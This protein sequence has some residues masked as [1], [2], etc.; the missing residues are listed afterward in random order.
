MI[1]QDYIMRLIEQLVKVLAK[2]LFNKKAGNYN[3]ALESINVALNALVGLDYKLIDELGAN[4]IISLL[5]YANEKPVVNIKC[6]VAAKLI[7]EKSDLLKLNK[8]E[9]LTLI[10]NY[11]KAV[12]L[13]LEGIINGK[14][15]EIDL[16]NFYQDVKALAGLLGDE[17]I[18]EIRFKLFKFYELSGEYN[19]A[20]TELF[21]LKELGYP[22]IK[23]EGISFFNKL[24]KLSGNELSKGSLLKAGLDR[25]LADFLKDTI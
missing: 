5:D 1:F 24:E 14:N 22:N 6:I 25:S 16:S 18:P 10:P 21:R 9:N 3:G 7:K 13:I 20:M 11:Q 19:N 17:I 12:N 4:D 8:T 23:G 2:I 15:A